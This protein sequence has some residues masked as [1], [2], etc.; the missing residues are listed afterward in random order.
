MWQSFTNKI[1][2]AFTDAA[3]QYDIL[4]SL[5]KEIGRELVKKVVRL[6]ANR[7]LDVGCGTGYVANKAKFFY[8]ESTIV[9]LDLA[10]GM[11]Q[12]ASQLHEGIDIQWL[13]A[14]GK[15]LPF[16]DNSFDLILSNLAYQW[17]L[18][19]PAAF[20]DARRVLADKGTLNITLFGSHT[21]QELFD[22]LKHC[23]PELVQDLRRLPTIKHVQEALIDA[24]FHDSNVDYELIKVQFKDIWEL[25]TWMKAIGANRLNQESFLGK[26]V[27]AKANEYYLQHFPY[28]NGICVSFEVIWV[29][30]RIVE[31]R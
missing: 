20:K 6:E 4:T 3:D 22:S 10:E 26:N 16:K 18:D 25:L 8:P 9:G 27:L 21:C 14:D 17:V 15:T 11:L 7:I 1:R 23:V 31:I 28:N 13:Q 2:K 19:L 29:R 30:S 24:G 5:H 12:K